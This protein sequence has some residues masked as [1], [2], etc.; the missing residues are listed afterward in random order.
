MVE[1]SGAS[2]VNAA[3]STVMHGKNVGDILTSGTS[4]KNGIVRM[5]LF[6]QSYRR[7]A[8]AINASLATQ[9]T[10]DN[11]RR[12]CTKLCDGQRKGT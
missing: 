7:A 6:G 5:A 12:E 4:E 10:K 3:K 9:E 1:D 2:H 11:S 8:R